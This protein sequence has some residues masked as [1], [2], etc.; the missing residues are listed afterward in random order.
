MQTKIFA[1]KLILNL[2]DRFLILWFTDRHTHNPRLQKKAL[3]KMK[4]INV[5]F[6][7]VNRFIVENSSG[8]PAGMTAPVFKSKAR[9]CG[10]NKGK[11][12][13]GEVPRS[14]TWVKTEARLTA[15]A[16]AK[17]IADAGKTAQAEEAARI[18]AV[19][20]K[21]RA[22]AK[23]ARIEAEKQ[24]RACEKKA[25][26]KTILEKKRTRQRAWEETEKVLRAL[27]R[28]KEKNEAVSA[29]GG[30]N[31]SG[32]KENRESLMRYVKQ[33]AVC[34]A[35]LLTPLSVNAVQTVIHFNF[36]SIL[37]SIGSGFLAWWLIA[38]F[39]RSGSLKK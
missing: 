39:S 29:V 1:T 14:E 4:A 32:R 9:F 36:T 26:E 12:A 23:K 38:M 33:I 11:S 30:N 19:E 28:A 13:S 31:V 6:E 5:A 2:G 25:A 35:V 18:A 34:C 27:K 7:H 20:E 21:K 3:E 24:A 17:E 8:S 15:L 22:A 10:P 16:R 37:I